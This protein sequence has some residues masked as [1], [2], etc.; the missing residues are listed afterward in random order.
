MLIV[1]HRNQFSWVDRVFVKENGQIITDKTPEELG[2]K[3]ARIIMSE[4]DLN[5]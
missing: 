5:N 1:T 4:V 2:I 3:K